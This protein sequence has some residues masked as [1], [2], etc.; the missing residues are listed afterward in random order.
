MALSHPV[1][2]LQCYIKAIESLFVKA[3]EQT[4]PLSKE[5]CPPFS[6]PKPHES[7]RATRATISLSPYS[8][9]SVVKIPGVT[10]VRSSISINTF[11]FHLTLL[12]HSYF[13]LHF[14]FYA[15]FSSREGKRAKGGRGETHSGS[16]C[17]YVCYGLFGA[18]ARYLPTSSHSLLLLYIPQHRHHHRHHH[19]RNARQSH[20]QPRGA[21]RRLHRALL[22]GKPR[23][24]TARAPEARRSGVSPRISYPDARVRRC[25]LR[26]VEG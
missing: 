18:L 14:Y 7:L 10:D 5:E 25:R 19:H 8:T 9:K 1:T 13:Y 16:V 11:T 21:N 20:L 15:Y 26:G 22:R 3:Q 2:L 6:F 23:Q 24:R 17:E 12:L 4:E